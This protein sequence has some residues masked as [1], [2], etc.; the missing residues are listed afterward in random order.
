MSEPT[1]K[2]EQK[3]SPEVLRKVRMANAVNTAM[4]ALLQEHR[5]E[6][7]NRARA[8]LLAQGITVSDAELGT[9]A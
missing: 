3:L 6:I 9:Q 2:P 7:I 1:Q 4:L 8:L 5:A